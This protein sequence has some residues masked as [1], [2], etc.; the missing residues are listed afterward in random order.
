M[1]TLLV[2]IAALMLGPPAWSQTPPSTAPALN[3]LYACAGIADD[4]ARLACYDAATGRLRQAESQGQVA[5]VDR[6]RARQLER[7]S[8][9]F[10]LPS[11][12]RLLGGGGGERAIENIQANVSRVRELANGYHSF[13][14]DNGQVWTQIE[15]QGVRNVRAGDSVR[16]E[17]A[18]M[19]SFRL[20]SSRGG[21]GH[22]VRREN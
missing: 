3:D 10:Q 21:A 11:L 15:P 2:L 13:V 16:I 9:G 8:F 1:R 5:V 4:A 14:L 17:R 20:I 7:E 6:E 12:S 19:G 22:R 18:A